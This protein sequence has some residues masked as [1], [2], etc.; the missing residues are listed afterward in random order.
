MCP[1]RTL[2]LLCAC[3]AVA[4]GKG[5]GEVK[6]AGKYRQEGK[7]Y[8]VQDGDIIHFQVGPCTRR[9]RNA[10]CIAVCGVCSP[11]NQAGLIA[12]TK[13][14]AVGYVHACTPRCCHSSRSTHTHQCVY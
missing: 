6:A 8:V 4:A 10:A 13:R 9:R 3:M 11:R 2:L 1:T 7:Q 14:R 5:M 12:A